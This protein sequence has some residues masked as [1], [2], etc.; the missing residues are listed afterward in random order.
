MQKKPK[1]LRDSIVIPKEWALAKKRAKASFDHICAMCGKELDATA[2]P[3]THNAIE[4]DHIIPLARG[5]HPTEL[6]NLQ[7]ACMK[8][9]RTKGT[10]M[11]SDYEGLDLKAPFPISNDW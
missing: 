10:K 11:A 1:K 5:G 8:C 7:L 9:N 3:Y 4:I 6:S 2:K